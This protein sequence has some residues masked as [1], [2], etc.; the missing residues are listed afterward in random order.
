MLGGYFPV[1]QALS[2]LFLTTT[3]FRFQTGT[4]RDEYLNHC[5]LMS[6]LIVKLRQFSNADC[7]SKASQTQTAEVKQYI[8]QHGGPCSTIRIFAMIDQI[9]RLYSAGTEDCP[10]RLGSYPMQRSLPSHYAFRD[11]EALHR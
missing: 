3:Y 10:V 4:K 1:C 5:Q 7:R 8:H 11:R 9:Q 6:K 2:I